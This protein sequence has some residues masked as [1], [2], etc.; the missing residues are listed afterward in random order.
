MSPIDRFNLDRNRVKFLTDDAYSAEVFFVEENRKVS[1]TNVFSINSQRYEC[2]VD[3]REK[4]VQVRYDRLRRDR[5]V[6]YFA[7]QRMGEATE[8]NLYT[9]ARLRMSDMAETSHD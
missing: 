1:K 6:V 2:P 7:G 5:Y 3:L 8:L 9:N 4:A